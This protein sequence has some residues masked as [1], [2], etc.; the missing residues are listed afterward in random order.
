[1]KQQDEGTALASPFE[2]TALPITLKWMNTASMGEKRRVN[3]EV[4]IPPSSGLVGT[5]LNAI[6]LDFIATATG[7]KRE[8][9]GQSSKGVRSQLKPEA[10]QQIQTHGLTYVSN[11]D[12]KPGDYAVRLLV[13]DNLTGRLGS[14]IAPLHVAP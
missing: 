8:I 5:D 12:L 11:L 1:M 13:R 6:D 10:Q 14:V 7:G 9:A 4:Y 2:Y 3:F